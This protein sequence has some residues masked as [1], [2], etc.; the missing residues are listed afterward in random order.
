MEVKGF[1]LLK[2][3]KITKETNDCNENAIG[4]FCLVEVKGFGLS[5]SSKITK[6]TNDCK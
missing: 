6:E 2:S 1:D 3:S 5:K 4:I